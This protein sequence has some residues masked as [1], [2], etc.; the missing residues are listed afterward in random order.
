IEARRAQ[1]IRQRAR[2]GR[3]AARYHRRYPHPRARL[4]A[5]R[6]GIAVAHRAGRS[7]SLHA[8]G[9]ADRIENQRLKEHDMSGFE[10]LIPLASGGLTAARQTNAMAAQQ[11]AEEGHAAQAAET[12]RTQ[13][14]AS[15]K[16]AEDSRKAALKRAMARQRA[17]SGA[18]G[19]SSADG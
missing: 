13:I 1:A 14:A 10:T 15:A 9:G 8:A 5:G 19:I 18:Q 16:A 17:R 3:T 2:A 6:H 7:L 4:A 12:Q 11:R